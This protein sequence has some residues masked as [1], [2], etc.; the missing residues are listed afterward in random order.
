MADYRGKSSEEELRFKS[1]TVVGFE[2]GYRND[3]YG[4]NNHNYQE[5][6]V[7]QYLKPRDGNGISLLSGIAPIRHNTTLDPNWNSSVKANLDRMRIAIPELDIPDSVKTLAHDLIKLSET[8]Q[9]KDI[10]VD[11]LNKIIDEIDKIPQARI[12]IEILSLTYKNLDVE[13]RDKLSPKVKDLVL[14]YTLLPT[15]DKEPN[16]NDLSAYLNAPF[17]ELNIS[18]LE[19]NPELKEILGQLKD[20]TLEDVEIPLVQVNTKDLT[21]RDTGGKGVFDDIASAIFNQLDFIRSRNLITQAEFAEVYKTV[22]V[23]GIQTAASFAIEKAN[24]LNQSYGLKLQAANA[25]IAMLNAKTQLLMLPI[26][27][28]LQYAQLE[29]QLKQLEL[30][31]IQTEIEKEKYPQIVAQTDLILAQTDSQRL[32]NEQAQVGIQ[33]GKLQLEQ[34][35]EQIVLSQEQNKQA[36]LQTQLQAHQIEQ[37]KEQTK[38]LALNNNQIIEQTKSI[39]AQTQVQL[40]QVELADVQKIRAKAEVKLMAEQLK[41]SKQQTLL[42]KANVANTYA[43][44]TAA[45]EQIRAAKAQY[46]DTIDGQPIGGVL[47]AQINVNKA[48]A[49]GFERSAFNSFLSQ[50]IQGWNTKKTA[51]IATLSPNAFTALGVDKLLNIGAVQQFGLPNDIFEMPANYRDYLTDGEMDGTESTP[52]TSNATPK[53]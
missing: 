17:P 20:L 34:V 49:V 18:P 1:D 16:Y 45:Q 24:V 15:P 44:L 40:K 19:E 48:Q 52:S 37:A 8:E 13:L 11:A 33:T 25:A 12:L 47:G 23:Q 46:S 32:Q 42:A 7:A 3:T 4:R 27:V 31:K 5:I 29:T 26:Q 6:N 38:Q 10:D 2:K 9:N 39:D 41:T 36:Q 53:P 51:D 35:K 28:R 50:V 22:L 43:Q 21:E 14:E 30:L